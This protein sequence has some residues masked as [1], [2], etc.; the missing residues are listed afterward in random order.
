MLRIGNV[1]LASDGHPLPEYNGKITMGV[2]P[3]SI[4][5]CDEGIPAV[6]DIVE[7]LGGESYIYATCA[8][9]RITIRKQGATTLRM[10]DSICVDIPPDAIHLFHP[11]TG[12]RI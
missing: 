6:V 4:S 7:A 2:R 12:C 10:G 9:S 8:G 11:D 5:I 3:D 1:L